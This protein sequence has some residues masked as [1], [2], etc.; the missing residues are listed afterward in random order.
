MAEGGLPSTAT[1]DYKTSGLILLINLPCCPIGFVFQN[2]A[3]KSETWLK[4]LVWTY[5][6]QEV[7]KVSTTARE[8][9]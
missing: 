4:H 8:N 1:V 2:Y 5:L 3:P 9:C 6:I 7:L